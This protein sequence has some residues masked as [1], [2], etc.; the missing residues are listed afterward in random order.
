MSDAGAGDTGIGQDVRRLELRGFSRTVAEVEWLLVLLVMVFWLFDDEI[1]YR[2]AYL[3]ATLTYVAAVLSLRYAPF[4]AQRQDSVLLL[5]AVLMTVFVALL[6]ALSGHLSSP[7][8]NL[9]LLPI[10]VAALTLGRR[11]TLA[12]VV[13][14]LGAVL[15]LGYTD[16]S[17]ARYA[18]PFLVRIALL[19][20]PLAL[21]A[22]LTVMLSQDIRASRVRVRSLLDTDALTGLY[23]LRAFNRQL[24]IVHDQATADGS[25][26]SVVMMDLDGLKA[27]NDSTGHDEGNRVLRAAARG[28]AGSLR[29][30]DMPV[31]YGGDEFVVLLPET[32]AQQAVSVAAR[33]REAVSEQ[34]VE[35]NGR[36]IHPSISAGVASFPTDSSDPAELVRLAD[37]RMYAQKAGSLAE[38]P[39]ADSATSA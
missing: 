21:I 35:A 22:A 37:E 11:Q 2:A 1:G 3:G 7:L 39:R 33:I 25:H 24:R 27:I 23:N 15:V 6:S 32:D 18:A 20:A 16:P 14:I 34:S 30:Q 12:L 10:I 5:E 28:I 9:F 13:L 17:I 29:G 4:F 36:T 26:Y 19:V 31:R 8:L 38:R